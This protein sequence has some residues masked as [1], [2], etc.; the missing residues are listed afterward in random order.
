[1]KKVGVIGGGQLAMMLGVAAQDLGIELLVQTPKYSDPAVRTASL[2]V[3]GEINDIAA[4]MRLADC[5][6]VITFENEF[7][8]LESLRFLEDL[9]A[10]FLPSLDSLTC[11]LDKYHQLCFLREIGVPV[12]EFSLNPIGNVLP[13]VIKTRRNGYDGYGTKIVDTLE[14]E[15]TTDVVYQKFVSISKE[16][17]VICARNAKGHIVLYPVVETHQEDQVC[18]KVI[19]PAFINPKI[20]LRIEEICCSILRKLRYVGVLG[21]EFFLT[22]GGEILVNELAPR[23][24]NSG[25]YTI[26]ACRTSQFEMQLRAITGMPLGSP[27]LLTKRA[28][29]INLF[30][31]EFPSQPKIHQHWYRKAESRSGRKMGHITYTF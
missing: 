8:D 16:L 28:V 7:V 23:T 17:A 20:E 18:R 9:G 19:A 27:E 31:E 15:P 24:H 13:Q 30:G 21:V 1:M 26:D 3:P 22:E 11:I 12:P 14:G 6:D 10:H 25:H 29:M 5:C 4:T 2:V